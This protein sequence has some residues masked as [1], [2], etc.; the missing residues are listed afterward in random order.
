[1]R[2]DR[3]RKAALG[4]ALAAVCMAGLV[5]AF[6]APPAGRKSAEQAQPA[7]PDGKPENDAPQNDQKIANEIEPREIAPF[8][9]KGIDWL[10]EAQHENGGWGGGS[11]ANQQ[12]RDPHNIQVDPAT[13][14]FAAM[15][16][17]RAG[18]TPVAGK[19]KDSVRKATGFLVETVEQYGNPSS[20]KITDITGTQPQAKLGPLVDTSM[21][22]QFLARVLTT[23]PDNDPIRSRVD[24]ALDVCVAKLEK[25][26]QK[27]GSWNL[28]GAGWAPVLQSSLGCNALELAEVAGKPVSAPALENARKYQKQNFD[29]KSGRVDA[30]A[31]AGVALY[32]FSGAQRSNAAE[33]KAADEIVANAKREGKLAADAPVSER[34]LVQLGVSERQ[35]GGLVR[36]YSDFNAQSD[37]LND[38]ALL[39][40]FGNNGGE[41]FLSFLLTSESM[42]I[43]GGKKWDEWN[44]K[45]RT[46][47]EK[48][49]NPDGSWSGHHCITSPVFC[50]AAVVQCL[51]T[52]RDAKLLIQIAER[53]ANG[54]A[55]KKQ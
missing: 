46:R 47:L 7:E 38:E 48:V 40:G 49:Q 31:A 5:V 22:A 33:A 51:T 9:R 27:D 2:T 30:S 23:L 34:S 17:L 44:E 55:P 10:V 8:L 14:A 37:R 50:T 35:A 25:S 42:V 4:A 20:P 11:H 18:H 13:T 29:R 41:E 52:D 28:A 21:A 43:A 36:A 15:A 53:A 54:N 1:M 3:L 12:N 16:L 45:I 24:A 26:Q 39:R 6:A 19:Y 32:A